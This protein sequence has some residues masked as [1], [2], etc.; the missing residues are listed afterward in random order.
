[1]TDCN[2]ID[3]PKDVCY[4]LFD[5]GNPVIQRTIGVTNRDE[6]VIADFDKGGKIIGLELLGSKKARKPCQEY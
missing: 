4:V 2:K 5:S 3:I 6:E 1:M